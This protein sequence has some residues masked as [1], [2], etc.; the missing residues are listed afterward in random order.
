MKKLKFSILL[1]LA[2]GLFPFLSNSQVYKTLFAG[3]IQFPSSVKKVPDIRVYC[4]GRK[5]SGAIDKEAGKVTYDIFDYHQKNFFLIAITPTVQFTKGEG[6]T[7]QHLKIKQGQAYK[8]YAIE[9]VMVPDNP[10]ETDIK[11][12]AKVKKM[13][14]RHSWII[15]DVELS[16][17]GQLPDDTII[18]CYDP[19]YVDRLEG[20][21][22]FEFPKIMIRSDI[23][24]TLG[25]EQQLIEKSAE[26]L[27]AT[28]DLDSLHAAVRQEIK[29]FPAPKTI[30]AFNLQ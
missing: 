22:A 1:V 24:T 5:I 11:D 10:G 29:Q 9:H 4:G 23:L 6:N 13:V 27:L 3:T 2:T 12:D 25:S 21:N 17:T 18:V 30:L 28:L 7:I 20:G 15:K 16:E 8:L 19:A 26:I 14:M